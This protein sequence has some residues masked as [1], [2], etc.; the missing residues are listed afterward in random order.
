M[1]GFFRRIVL[2]WSTIKPIRAPGGTPMRR[3]LYGNSIQPRCDVCANGRRS[4]DGQA[5]LCEKKGVVPLYHCCR[6]FDYDPLK[7]VPFRQPALA[8]YTEE[9]FR[10]D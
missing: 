10:L 2:Y 8:A 6:K 7:R 1:S 5:V 4:S 3:K 9:D